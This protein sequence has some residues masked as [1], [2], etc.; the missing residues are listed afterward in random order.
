V[1]TLEVL[2]KSVRRAD[3]PVSF[4]PGNGTSIRDKDLP[5]VFDSIVFE[6]LVD[7]LPDMVVR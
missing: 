1:D 2:R 7:Q 4:V 5:V 3:G 6:E